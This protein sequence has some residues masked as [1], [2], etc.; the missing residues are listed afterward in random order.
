MLSIAT[1]LSAINAG[2]TLIPQ[3]AQLIAELK[4]IFNETD[5][6]AIEKA[7]ADSTAGADAQH[8]DAQSF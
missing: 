4:G 8:R 7:L 3:G 6:A 1:V 2:V 5:Q